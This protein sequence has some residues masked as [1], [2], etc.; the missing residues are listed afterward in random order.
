MIFNLTYSDPLLLSFAI[1]LHSLAGAIADYAVLQVLL[2][3]KAVWWLYHHSLGWWR[4]LAVMPE[5]S[6]DG[7]YK[8]FVSFLSHS[9]PN[10][11]KTQAL[12]SK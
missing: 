2:S 7:Q 11:Y 1:L 9:L 3:L 12:D 5:K 8:L 6:S 4:M 10:D